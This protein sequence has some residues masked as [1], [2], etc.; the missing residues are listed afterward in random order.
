MNLYFLVEGAKTEMIVYPQ[1]LSYLIP[2]LTQAE[3]ISE[4]R[5][6]NYF[7]LSGGGVP[8]IYDQLEKTIQDINASGKF[9]YLV[10]CV[11]S[12]EMTVEEKKEE[13]HNKIKTKNLE[14][15]DCHLEIIVQNVCIETWFLGNKKIFPNDL[16]SELFRKYVQHYNVREN[17]PERMPLLPEAEFDTHAQFHESYLRELFKEKFKNQPIR[18]SKNHPGEVTK[19]YYLKALQQ[20]IL[21]N[22]GHLMSFQYFI[23]FCTEIRVLFN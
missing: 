22:P 4:V 14:L 18:Y 21:D 7:M 15:I 12:D 19:E 13:I 8:Q 9:K 10:F 16:D 11:D 20:R 6:N 1:W 2:Q 3:S 5:E 23:R 17:D